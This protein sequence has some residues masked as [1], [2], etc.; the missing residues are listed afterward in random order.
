MIELQDKVVVITG[1]S[2]GIGFACA[3]LL[4]ENGAKVVLLSRNQDALEKAKQRILPTEN[5][6]VFPCDITS[7]DQVRITFAG[8]IQEFKAIDVLVNSAGYGGKEYLVDQMPLSNFDLTLK[9]N[10]VGTFL[11]C[12]EVLSSMKRRKKGMIINIS[13]RAGKRGFPLFAHYCAAK[14]A[15]AGFTQSLQSEVEDYGIRAICIFPGPTNTPMQQKL[16]N[17]AT[18]QMSPQTV[19]KIIANMILVPNDA[20]VTEA[21]IYPI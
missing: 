11:C 15:V 12:R 8:I 6:F 17:P 14:F 3:E 18:K 21:S 10:L 4:A 13:S 7:E 19:A 2:S 9:T 16:A 20:Y 1:G 5:V